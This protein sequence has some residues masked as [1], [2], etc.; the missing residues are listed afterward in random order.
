MIS[1]YGFESI[2]LDHANYQDILPGYDHGLSV[3]N[4]PSRHNVL[5]HLS[6]VYFCWGER[7]YKNILMKY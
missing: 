7:I 5:C 3:E 1:G 6:K 4:I 2:Y